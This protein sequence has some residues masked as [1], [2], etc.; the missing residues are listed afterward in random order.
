MIT[1]GLAMTGQGMIGAAALGTTLDF[2]S[3]AT[4]LAG[5]SCAVLIG[6]FVAICVGTMRQL[7]I[8]TIRT[9]HGGTTLHGSPHFARTA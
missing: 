6:G 4:V 9:T 1:M 7:T 8:P 3:A 2:G 5:V